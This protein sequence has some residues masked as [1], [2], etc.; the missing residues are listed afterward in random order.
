MPWQFRAG[1]WDFCFNLEL[2]H[3]ISLSL[4]FCDS[5]LFCTAVTMR[6]K[7]VKASFPA[8]LG[9]ALAVSTHHRSR[10]QDLLCCKLKLE[11]F[12]L[13]MC[14]WR[15]TCCDRRKDMEKKL[16]EQSAWDQFPHL[17][18]STFSTTATAQ[19]LWVFDM[20]IVLHSPLIFVWVVILTLITIFFQ[21][22]QNV[23]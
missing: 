15:S 1:L 16:Q 21:T 3:T 14:L 22:K 11:T 23:L 19:L 18:I 12:Q 6:D 13:I 2:M 4:D 7:L 20:W 8:S 17:Q 5:R 10:C 9:K